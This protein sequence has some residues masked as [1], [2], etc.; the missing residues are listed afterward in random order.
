MEEYDCIIIGGGI[1]ALTGALYLGRYERKVLVVCDSF[2]GQIATA[3][4]IENFPTYKS[5]NGAEIITKLKAQV[6]SLSSVELKEGTKVSSVTEGQNGFEVKSNDVNFSGKSILIATGKRHRQLGLE[7]EDELTGKGVSYCATCDSPFAKD[8]RVAVVGGGNSAIEAAQILSKFTQKIYLVNIN[9]KLSGE[10]VRVDQI[11][12]DEKIE[13]MPETT[14][15]ALVADGGT[16]SAI[17]IKDKGGNESLLECQMVFIE[18]GW[19]PNSENFAQVVN[20]NEKK[21]I[22]IE[23]ETNQA[24]KGIFAAGDITDVPAKQAI[25]AAGEGAKAAIAI[26]QYL[27]NL[28]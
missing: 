11:E 4:E 8:K 16:L 24:Q 6:E 22:I 9:E 12:A 27:E 3:G 17:K 28:D 5:I 23:C 10:K 1:A 19:V 14:V 26:N 2:G 13:I 15:T 20:L 7:G 18:I 25:I 21:E